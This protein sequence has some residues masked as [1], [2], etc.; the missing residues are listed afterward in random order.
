[1]FLVGIIPGPDK[2]STDQI[3]HAIQLLVKV[4][5]EFWNPGVF[6]S[7]T[8]EHPLGKRFL[9]ML[10]PFIADMLAAR[11]VT[12]LPGTTMAH[13][14]C[15]FCDIDIDDLDVFEP[16]VWPAKDLQHIRNIASQY[17]AAANEKAQ[18]TLFDAYGIRWTP[19]LDLPYWDP[20]R[21]T[22]IDSMHALDLNLIHTHFRKIFQIDL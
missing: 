3:N 2:P 17:K 8:Y 20:I 1:I 11:Q 18:Q 13:Y 9:A 15:T 12:G 6:F 10:I 14:C 5:L 7:R 4:L 16:S 21:Y 22:V 19:L